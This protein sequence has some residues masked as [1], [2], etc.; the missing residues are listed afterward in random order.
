MA[1]FQNSGWN[2]VTIQSADGVGAKLVVQFTWNESITP[3]LLPITPSVISQ[4]IEQ[5]LAQGWQPDGEKERW[6]MRWCENRLVSIF[7][8]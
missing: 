7:E 6:H 3:Y 1:I 2:D 8:K 5:A 4:V